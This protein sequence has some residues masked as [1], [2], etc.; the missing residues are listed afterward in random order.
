M[1][2]NGIFLIS[3]GLLVFIIGAVDADG[4]I[5]NSFFSI[6]ALLLVIAGSL[7]F[8]KGHKKY[9]RL[10]KEEDKENENK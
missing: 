9:K 2:K 4:R 7:I 3:I 6:L 8:Y 1:V 10:K 5:Q